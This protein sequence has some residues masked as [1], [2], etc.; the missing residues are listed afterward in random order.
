[1]EER[2]L[3]RGMDCTP[4]IFEV[5]GATTGTWARYLKKLS[6]IAHTRRGHNEKRFVAKWRTRIAMTLAKRGAQVAIRRSHAIQC[7]SN[8][9]YTG[10]DS[11]GDDDGPMGAFG[12]EQ[13][14]EMAAD[15]TAHIMIDNMLEIS[16][17]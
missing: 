14:T 1:M 17:T 3:Q 8:S 12:V 6:E 16:C 13:R 9:S 5:D 2:L 10:W 11:P 7:S 4:I 15:S